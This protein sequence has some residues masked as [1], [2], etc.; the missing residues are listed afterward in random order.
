MSSPHQSA[1]PDFVI[2]H[3]E[4]G[5]YET[6]P[7]NGL[8]V[9]G[10]PE[11]LEKIWDYEPGGH[12]PVHL[13][14]LLHGRYKVL[15]KLGR[16]GY[17]NVWLCSDILVE[18][19]QPHY[20]ALKI[21]IAEVSTPDCTGLRMTELVRSRAGSAPS[22]ELSSFPLDRF[23]IKGPNGVHYV[24]VYPVLGPR[25]ADLSQKAENV[26]KDTLL[27]TVFPGSPCH[28]AFTRARNLPWRHVSS[29]L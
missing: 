19:D 15:H 24:F 4:L 29:E 14:D 10:P 21:M 2:P 3:N 12:H 20:V 18:V 22:S 5:D 16:E 11:G 27:R 25:V 6:F 28:G 1:H 7:D 13:G 26:P 17:S 23:E 8:R 9:E